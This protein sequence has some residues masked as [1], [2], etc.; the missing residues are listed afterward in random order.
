M[1]KE[2]MDNY[3]ISTIGRMDKPAETP[4][5]EAYL[6]HNRI[7]SGITKEMHQQRRNEILAT[8]VEDVKEFAAMLKKLVEN[9][10]ICVVGNETKIEK[11]RDVF[12]SVGGI[13]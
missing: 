1:T 12:D 11:N 5:N 9:G 8:T 10:C 3:I 4:Y 6:M 13:R 2:E 7:L